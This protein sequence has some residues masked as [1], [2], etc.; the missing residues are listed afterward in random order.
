MKYVYAITILL[1]VALVA[2]SQTTTTQTQ[3]TTSTTTSQTVSLQ[4]EDLRI[5]LSPVVGTVVSGILLV[6]VRAVP[7]NGHQLFVFLKPKNMPASENPFTAP[8]TIVEFSSALISLVSL[9]T[10]TIQNGNYELIVAVSPS[11]GESGWLGEIKTD[12]IVSN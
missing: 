4:D 7:E 10:S 11:S 1:L 5:Q 8:N 9:D 3:S 2:C 6:D 12:L